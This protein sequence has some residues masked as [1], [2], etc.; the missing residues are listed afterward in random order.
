[1]LS[2]LQQTCDSESQ[3]KVIIFKGQGTRLVLP[4]AEDISF[5]TE[6]VRRLGTEKGAPLTV[7]VQGTL[8]ILRTR[9]QGG[10]RRAK[11][12]IVLASNGTGFSA[13]RK[14]P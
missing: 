2:V 7:K 5:T 4:F 9:G 8:G 6:P 13:Q 1:M 14:G 10:P 3:T 12:L 11:V